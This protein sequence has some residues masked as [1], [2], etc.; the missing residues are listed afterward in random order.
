[1]RQ[2]LN[3][4]LAKHFNL[5]FALEILAVNINGKKETF[6]KIVQDNLTSLMNLMQ[7]FV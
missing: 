4:C 2:Y 7:L 5:C 6:W 3:I 1:M